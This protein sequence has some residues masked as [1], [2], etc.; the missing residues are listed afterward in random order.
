MT[1]PCRPDQILN[2]SVPL[3]LE[4]DPAYRRAA[5]SFLLACFNNDP[6]EFIRAYAREMKLARSDFYRRWNR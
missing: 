5:W 3:R 2:A 4:N 6:R 1:F